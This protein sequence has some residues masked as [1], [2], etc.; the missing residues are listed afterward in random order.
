MTNNIKIEDLQNTLKEVIKK[1]Y[2][3]TIQLKFN[4]FSISNFDILRFCLSTKDNLIKLQKYPIEL[5]INGEYYN[6]L[7]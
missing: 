5:K 4:G 3:E 7:K 6:I 1:G 2:G